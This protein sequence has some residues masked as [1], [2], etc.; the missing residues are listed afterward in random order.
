MQQAIGEQAT[1]LALAFDKLEQEEEPNCTKWQ[2]AAKQLRFPCVFSSFFCLI[3]F[4][5]LISYRRYWDWA[6]PK[7]EQEGMPSILYAETVSLTVPKSEDKFSVA[8]PLA[9]FPIE[10]I[11]DD[12]TDEVDDEVR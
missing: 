1:A 2:E 11:P 3:L 9:L 10:I 7:V 12:F 4:I 5:Y 6:S 8:N